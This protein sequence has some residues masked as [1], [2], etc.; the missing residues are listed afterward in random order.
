MYHRCLLVKELGAREAAEAGYASGFC[1][2]G[3]TWESGRAP[4]GMKLR[5]FVLG[6]IEFLPLGA[7]IGLGGYLEPAVPY[8]WSNVMGIVFSLCVC[9]MFR[10]QAPP[11]VIHVA[12]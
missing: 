12:S 4:K 8:G 11:T 2:G 1:A 7:T 10:R 6:G 9:W 5:F 3:G